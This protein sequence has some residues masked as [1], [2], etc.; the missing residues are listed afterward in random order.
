M[1]KTCI[2]TIVTLAVSKVSQDVNYPRVGLN[3]G[4]LVQIK[5]TPEQNSHGYKRLQFT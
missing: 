1:Y 5:S 4:A 2:F 3:S